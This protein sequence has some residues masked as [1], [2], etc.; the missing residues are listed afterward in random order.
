MEYRER[1]E[2]RTALLTAIRTHFDSQG[3]LEVDTPVAITAPA[4]AAV[5][6]MAETMGLRRRRMLRITSP[7]MRANFVRSAAS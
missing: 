1:M 4:P 5:P 2:P 7:V 3:F 6:L